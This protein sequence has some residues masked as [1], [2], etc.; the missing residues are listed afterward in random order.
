VTPA[1]A[2]QLPLVVKVFVVVAA[3]ADEAPAIMPNSAKSERAVILFIE[4]RRVFR[5]SA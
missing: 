1:G 3:L 5:S 2:V 4:L